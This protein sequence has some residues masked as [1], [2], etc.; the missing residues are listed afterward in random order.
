MNRERGLTGFNSYARELGFNP[1][2]VL[3]ARLAEADEAGQPGAQRVGWLDLCCGVGRALFEAGQQLELARLAGRVDLVGVDL[4]GVFARTDVPVPNLDLI[5]SSVVSF[6]PARDFDLITCVHGLHY[7]GDKL[8][9]L[10]RAAGWLTPS[11]LL[12]ADLD[13]T[14]V[15]L[16]DGRPAGRQLVSRLRAAGFSYDSR[17]RRIRRTGPRD[18]RLPYAY[19]GADDK[20]GANYTG[21][22]AVR[23]YYREDQE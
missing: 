20:A 4:V 19:L 10:T 2:D 5:C 8:S 21:Q 16:A 11:G 12:I 6:E 22:P 13:L 14:G 9:V 15:C 3:T 1:L 7:V 23:S 17:R 18:V